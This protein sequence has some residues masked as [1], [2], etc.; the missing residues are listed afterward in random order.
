MTCSKVKKAAFVTLL[1]AWGIVGIHEAMAAPPAKL[2]FIHHSCGE[3]WLADDNG[4]LG[5]A[6]AKA[7]YFVS[8]TNYGW[9]PDGIGDRTDIPN[10]P[11]WF[12]GPDSPRILT[13]LF[14]E[15]ESHAPYARPLPDPGGPNRI[16]LFKSCFPNS[17]LGGK[18]NDPPN[19]DGD[20]T[21][22]GAKGVYL[23]LRKA[24]LARPDTFF[25]VV[26]A[27]PVQAKSHAKNA[28][29]F[30]TWLTTEWLKGYPGK[31]VAVFDFYTVLTG[32][33]NH[34]RLRDGKV[35]YVNGTGS[36][37]L[38]Y[39]SD[40]DHPSAD[41]NRKAT[42][43]FVPFLDFHVRQWLA[44]NPPP[45][46]PTTITPP[47]LPSAQGL[48]PPPPKIAGP[49]PVEN[50]PAPPPIAPPRADAASANFAS[51]VDGWEVFQ[52]ESVANPMM[53]LSQGNVD[54]TPFLTVAYKVNANTWTACA[55]VLSAATD[56]RKHDGIAVRWMAP[57][58]CHPILTVYEN[59]P[60]NGLLHFECPLPAG[61]GAWQN[62]TL[63]W[64]R[65]R[66]PD[67]QGDV[68]QAFRPERARGVA[69][70]LHPDEAPA[71]GELR[72]AEVQLLP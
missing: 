14:R 59:G 44:S 51:S 54:G 72:I 39:P 3:N 30:N 60:D 23:Q 41:G 53:T 22:G 50:P 34:H 43:E 67:W 62:A 26:T 56:W 42:A 27:P 63:P 21:V 4:G 32:K 49:D 58:G 48:T 38:A 69:V 10:W 1:G 47:R 25:M 17:E 18:P 35:E 6:L 24:F 7:N 12:C 64:S 61:T 33:N 15:S 55:K 9:G 37:T 57:S 28:R 16:V 68:N 8:D 13:A 66:Q 11:E 70:I 31:N 19:A 71:N 46:P 2:V 40:D 65:F 5:A 36:N 29:A 52:D 20:L 45:T